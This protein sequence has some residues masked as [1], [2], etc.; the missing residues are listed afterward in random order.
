M[1]HPLRLRAGRFAVPLPVGRDA[2]PEFEWRCDVGVKVVVLFSMYFHGRLA[3]TCKVA[4]QGYSTAFRRVVYVCV[5]RNESKGRL[6]VNSNRRLIRMGLYYHPI[7]VGVIDMNAL[8][9]S[10]N[11]YIINKFLSI[12]LTNVMKLTWRLL[13]IC[14][15]FTKEI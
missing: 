2:T 4:R 6:S 11:I 7:R 9:C 5:L 13:D 3:P 1:T 15:S 10:R 14:V 12:D 8:M